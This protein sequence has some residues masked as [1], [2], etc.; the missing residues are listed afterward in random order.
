MLSQLA[1]RAYMLHF[2]KTKASSV[3]FS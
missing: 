3:L 1:M 2:V